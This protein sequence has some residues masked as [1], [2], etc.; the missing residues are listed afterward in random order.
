MGMDANGFVPRKKCACG[1]DHD[2]KMGYVELLKHA[3]WQEG[4]LSRLRE[5]LAD[6]EQQFAALQLSVI[7]EKRMAKITSN[8]LEKAHA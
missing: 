8:E 5:R 7:I 4:E 6:L 2:R 1:V 3:F